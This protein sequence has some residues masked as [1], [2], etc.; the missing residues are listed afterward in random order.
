MDRHRAEI[1]AFH[2]TAPT[3]SGVDKISVSAERLCQEIKKTTG[4]NIY[5]R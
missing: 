1:F 2:E 3:S 4:K 5:A